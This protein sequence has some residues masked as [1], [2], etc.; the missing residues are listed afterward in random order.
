LK[1]SDVITADS[2]NRNLDPKKVMGAAQVA[3]KKGGKL[4]HHGKTSLLLEKLSDGDY[5]THLFTQDSPVLLARA[6]AL[7]FRK[8]EKSDIRIIYGDATGPMLNLLRRVARQ[9]GA[10]IKD[11]DRHGFTWM[12][13][14]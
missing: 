13:K 3:I 4:F 14:L 1:P 2:H 12:I 9:V 6:L 11:S 5:S 10:P 8:M 7:F